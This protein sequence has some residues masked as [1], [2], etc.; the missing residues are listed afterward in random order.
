MV[1]CI[2][3]GIP[4]EKKEESE[5]PQLSAQPHLSDN[6]PTYTSRGVKSTPQ[7]NT[8]ETGTFQ[9]CKKYTSGGANSTPLAVQ[10]VHPINNTDFSNNKLNNTMLPSCHISQ[11][12]NTGI[13]MPK[14]EGITD[15][16]AQHYETVRNDVAEQIEADTLKEEHG[17]VIDEIVE[18]ITDVLITPMPSLRVAGA[19]R[20]IEVLRAQFAKLTAAHVEDALWNLCNHSSGEIT[21]IKAY[22]RTLLYNEL[23][24]VETRIAATKK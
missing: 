22:I 3:T 21:D 13:S 17:E 18:L 15:L 24:A 14:R 5:Q 8:V 10:I 12:I 6:S 2:E 7:D 20:P 19:N 23:F 11:S 4:A 9:R 1:T 16:T